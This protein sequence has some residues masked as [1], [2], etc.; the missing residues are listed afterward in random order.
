MRNIYKHKIF[1]RISSIFIVITITFTTLSSVFQYAF[2]TT[3]YSTL[4]TNKALG[5]P[6]LNTNF[7]VDNWNKWEMIAWG[8][9]LSNFANPFID[10]YNSAFNLD[11]DYGSKGSGAKALQFGSG[12]DVAN[13]KTIQSLLDYAIN[14]QSSGAVK[15]IYVSYNKLEDTKITEEDSFS[16][17]SGDT[18]TTNNT[19]STSNVGEVSSIREAT[20]KDLFF[21]SSDSG[22]NNT[23]ADVQ[24]ANGWSFDTLVT[25]TNY[26]SIVGVRNASIPV[27]AIETSGGGYQVVLDYTDSYDLSLSSLVLAKSLCGD[28]SNEFAKTF[29]D[30]WQ[31]PENYKVVLDCFGNICT[32]VDGSYRII[33]PAAANQYLTSNQ[34]I[35]LLNSLVFNSNTNTSSRNQLLLNGGQT[36]NNWWISWSG[37]IHGGVAAFGNQ[38]DGMSTGQPVIYF[39]TDTIVTQ[40]AIKS[41]SLGGYNVD[42]GDLYEKLY[43]LDMNNL[44]RADYMFKVE[45]ANIQS[46]TFELFESDSSAKTACETMILATSQLGN[47]FSNVPDVE[48]LTEMESSIGE[49]VSIFGDAI[50]VP[51]QVVESYQVY[52]GWPIT[53]WFAS[54]AEYNAGALHRSFADWVYQAY[55]H[56]IDTGKG[57]VLSSDVRRAFSNSNTQAELWEN[58]VKESPTSFKLSNLVKGFI[59]NKNA[60][61]K[62]KDQSVFDTISY[63][64]PS[65]IGLD[66]LP[67]AAQVIEGN[68]LSDNSCIDA[69]NIDFSF[70]SETSKY[71]MITSSGNMSGST[72]YGSTFDRSVKVYS[73][74]DVM[75]SVANVLGVREGTEFSVFSTD[76]YLTYLKWYGITSNSITSISGTNNTSKFNS[77]IFDDKSD[78]LNVDLNNLVESV[79]EEEKEKQIM[80]WTYMMLHPTEGREYRSNLIISGISDWIYDQYQKIVYGG[81]SSYYDAGSGVTSMNSTGF[82]TISPYS[83]NFMTAWLVNNYAYFISILMGVFLIL[84]VVIGILRKRKLSWFIVAILSTVN[85][86]LIL[87]STG[88][89]VPLLANN[90]VQD[91][92]KDK[93]S[94]WAISESVTNAALESDY[95]TNQSMSGSYLSTLSS[96]E[97]RQIVNLVKNYNVL[98]LDRSLNVK[99]DISKKVTQT[100]TSNYE[101]IQQL[102]SAR[103]MLP[104]IMRQFTASDESA[105]YIYVPLG[106]IYDDLSNMYWYFKPQDA[107]TVNTVNA[108]QEKSA[109]G[110][111]LPTYEF[112]GSGPDVTSMRVNYYSSYND[113]TTGYISADSGYKQQ[114]YDVNIDNNVHTYSYFIKQGGLIQANMPNYSS[115]ESYD[116]WAKEWANQLFSF[117]NESNLKTIEKY[118]EQNGGKYSR[119]DRGTVD[120]IYGYLWATESPY[121]YFYQGVKDSFSISDSLGSILGDLQGS[122]VENDDGIEVR[123]TF[124]HANDTGYVRDV[125]DLEEM[126][127]NMIPYL[128]SVQLYAEGYD[129]VGGVFKEGD[130][131]EEYKVYTDNDKSWLFRSN[132]VTKLMESP[133]YHASA[134]IRLPDGKEAKVSNMML[135]SCYE[136]AGRPMIFSEA[137][138]HYVGVDEA[139]LSLVELKCIEINK[140]VSKKWTMLLNY[141][142]LPGLTKE[143]LIRQMALDAL[144]TFNQEFTATGLLSSAYAMYPSGIDLRSI[145]FDS[146]MKMMMLNVTKDTSYIYGDTMQTI[147]EDS[148]ILT[149]LLLLMTAFICASI[150]PFARNVLM[151][152]IFFLGLFAIAWS[153]LRDTKTKAKVSCGFIVSNFVFLGMTFIYYLCFKAIM[154]MTVTDEV[155]TVSQIEVNSGNPIWCMLFV[156]I[157][158]GIYLFGIYKM[159]QLCIANFRD[160]GFEVYAGIAEMAATSISG[161]IEKVG[162]AISGSDSSQVR[163]TSSRGKKSPPVDVNNVTKDDSLNTDSSEETNRN[164]NKSTGGSDTNL[165]DIAKSSYIDQR[166]S[167][168]SSNESRDIDNEIKKGREIGNKAH[169][170]N[171]KY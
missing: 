10:D 9:F 161:A 6:V 127:N 72:V 22:D 129:G 80:D 165:D 45:P 158:S 135:P 104:M 146:I 128:Y 118:I 11:A 150:V 169:E 54:D 147:V 98:Y 52:E 64:P 4:G 38:T 143:V 92:F 33:F 68:A 154:A 82:M 89:V 35:N 119:F 162:S 49:S 76:I 94:Y 122:Y 136:E 61:Y 132:W 57:A 83:E 108:R 8:V 90:Y 28:Y 114:S 37:P 113:I 86:L 56:D 141:S 110:S 133:D 65:D 159:I 99:Q 115:Y 73:T 41:N 171:S 148:D 47:L 58:L 55:Q 5:S 79:S 138:M 155:L 124:M 29:S 107:A 31:N 81:A 15:K 66:F 137:Q 120:G 149:A 69:Y 12:N 106:D 23:W 75:K 112:T 144:L 88:D 67:I 100:S 78:V 77:R 46:V 157:I 168:N 42:T 121:H 96:D 53:G 105:N 3:A 36:R 44:S 167:D 16:K 24:D 17:S 160:M 71:E 93:M 101:D 40:D 139:D 34:S 14:Q 134:T 85:M 152:L 123:K 70:G 111:A 125:L 163:K 116:A 50:V 170:E 91:M 95:V 153:I 87:P 39:D 131:I 21:A 130:K 30:I 18:D 145:S 59:Q 2:G 74:S 32:V 25:T 103:W 140:E 13:R 26:L 97:Q 7:S 117:G 27:F 151:G 63:S 43:N 60:F 19:S 20:V 156:L 48:I 84:T 109:D 142:A 164:N 62:I 51:V 126:F 1:K 102:Q 166:Y